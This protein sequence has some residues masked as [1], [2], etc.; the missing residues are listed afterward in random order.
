MKLNSRLCRKT[1]SLA[2]ERAVFCLA[3]TAKQAILVVS[4]ME[5]DAVQTENEPLEARASFPTQPNTGDAGKDSNIVLTG[6]FIDSIEGDDSNSGTSQEA[7]WKSVDKV[8]SMTFKPGDNIYFK[9][10]SSYSEGLQING[11][12]TKENRILVS[13]YGEG[14]A[15][16]FT[17]HNDND[18]NGNC[19]QLNGDCQILENIYCHGTNAASKGGFL[20]IWKVAG[21]KINLGADHAIVRNNE[22]EDCPIGIN[23]YGEHT[24]ITKNYIHDC[25]RALNHPNWGPLGIRIGIG[26]HE[27]SHNRIHNYHSMGGTWGGDGGAIEIDDG[28][29]HHNNIYIHHNKSTMNMA[30]IETSY[31][32]DICN[33]DSVKC[34]PANRIFDNLIIAF[35]EAKDYRAFTQLQAPTRNAIIE[36]N[37][38]IRT[39]EHPEIES[40]VFFEL[41]PDEVAIESPST[42]RNNI[43]VVASKKTRVQYGN[44]IYLFLSDPVEIL[45]YNNLF[46]NIDGGPILMKDK[47]RQGELFA[48]PQFIDLEGGNYHLRSTSPAIGLG[49]YRGNYSVDLDGKPIDDTRDIGAYQYQ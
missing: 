36:N 13:A 12:G 30:F 46:F 42:Y 10:G 27:I 8:S 6:Y 19:I 28:R 5:P 47:Y 7:P 29:N 14:A 35:N 49:Y 9:R 38:I 41:D 1:P 17:N 39:I 25:N 33:R 22:V 18:Y 26:N 24:L 44:K 23:S 15:P 31:V 32:H 45:H 48:D 43:V 11:D 40:N 3:R 4:S 20:T 34:D 37:T 21:I 16:S 2:R